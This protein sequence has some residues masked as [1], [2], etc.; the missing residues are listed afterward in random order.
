MY[1]TVKYQGKFG[2]IKPWTAVRDGE[3]FSQQFLTPSIIE[4]IEKKLFPELLS[5]NGVIQK[6]IRHKLT[7]SAMDL[8]QETTQARGWKRT[9]KMMIRKQSIL[10]R[11]VMIDPILY[12]VF[13][14]KEDA[15]LAAKQHICLC[16]NEDLML[17]N[18]K[19]IV[20]TESEFDAIDGFELR[21][22]DSAQSF[23]V[24]FN[25]FDGVKP[26]YGW[27]EIC[28]KPCFGIKSDGEF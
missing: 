2:F 5:E 1:Y 19:I 14:H 11:G 26:M 28:G 9:K 3:T 10:K 13:D 18:E 20:L 22:G 8:Q 27:L 23:L 4:G 12:L 15:E 7:Y 6:I 25:R 21:F 16:R 17:P 24:G